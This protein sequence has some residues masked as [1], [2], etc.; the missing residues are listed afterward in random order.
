MNDAFKAFDL[1]GRSAVVTGGGTGIGYNLAKALV[2]SGAAVMIAARRDDVIEEAADRLQREWPEARVLHHVVDLADRQS[3]RS[4]ADHAASELGGVDIFVGNAANIVLE[5]VEAITDASMDTMFETSVAANIALV[6]QFLPGMRA[7]K[8]GR[9]IFSSST[10]AIRGLPTDGT[11]FYSTV[12]AAIEGFTRG[13]AT[14]TGHDGITV[15]SLRLGNFS[16]DLSNDAFARMDEKQGAGAGEAAQ[17][18]LRSMI[19]LGRFGKVEEVE[20]L[21]QLLASDAGSFITGA[22]L[23][24]D[25]G[26]SIMAHPK[27]PPQA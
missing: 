3:V 15:N 25:G 13:A 18:V 5:P 21:I 2:S 10:A 14:E 11:G 17:N 26:S 8:W 6:R 27:A 20:G 4:F 12:K 7:R 1:A 23:A 19:A 9:V 22:C 16:T 24:I